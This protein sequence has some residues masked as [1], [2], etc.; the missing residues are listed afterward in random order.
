MPHYSASRTKYI[1]PAIFVTLAILNIPLSFVPYHQNKTLHLSWVDPLGCCRAEVHWLVVL[2]PTEGNTDCCSAP[3][4][5]EGCCLEG[6]LHLLA[7]RI[8]IP[9]LAIR[10]RVATPPLLEQIA[11]EI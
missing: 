1:Q 11:G 4:S 10:L 7:G 6:K 2:R 8:A 3:T 9:V 5:T